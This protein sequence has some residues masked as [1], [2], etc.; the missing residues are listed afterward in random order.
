MRLYL[1]LLLLTFTIWTDAVWAA[2]YRRLVNFEWEAVEGAKGY[3]IELTQSK[4]D[5]KE[6]GQGKIYTFKVQEAAWNGRLTPGK[7]LMRLRTRDHRGV[8]GEWSPPSDF[9]VGLESATLTSPPPR[10]RIASKEDEKTKMNFQWNPVGGADQYQF[11]LTS[12]DGKT[13]ITETL[14]E[15]KISVE[16][17][18]ATN[19]TWKV[20]ALNKNGIQSDATSIGDFSVLGKP[21]EPPKIEKPES[22]FVREIK[23]T[24]PDNVT[25]YDV[26]V[27]KLNI[28][29][30]KWEKF[31]VIENTQEDSL[32]FDE[33]WP[34]GKYRVALRAKGPMRPSSTLAK[35]TFSVRHG[36]RSPAAEY[37][38]L[39]RKSIDRVTG[40]YGIASYL[41]T[42]MQFRGVNTEKNSAV[43]Y[44]AMGGTGRVGLGWFHPDTPWGFLGIIDLSGFTINGKTR[45]FASTE[46][47]A[48]YRKD[49]GDRSEVRVQIGPYY[50]EIPETVGD[51]FSGQSEDLK[52]SSAGPHAGIEYWFSL[53]P[54]L[55]VQLNAHL[56]MSLLKISTP[57][58]Q[59]LRP[60]MS[61]QFGFLGSYRFTPTFTGL[62]GYARR[63]D[64]VSYDALPSTSNFA[65]EGDKNDSTVVGNYIN[66]FAEWAF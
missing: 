55:G 41:L 10:A 52:I 28:K 37:T 13:Q 30:K 3:D 24:R 33:S 63:E 60:S 47:N 62:V 58:D 54:K 31:K 6:N 18:V 48:V 61:T 1:G 11:V 56:Y 59:A 12:E 51:P 29:D 22:D 4:E 21:L 36:D 35:N 27:F 16:V 9:N 15:N 40:W 46:L 23:W 44:S 2:P 32:A 53:T 26:Y 34:G 65:V 49:V 45:T 64:R 17:P 8:P 7:Y 38:A 5:D 14:S 66:F 57:N 50:K 20:T 25:S 39:V 42:E 43:A 19:Y